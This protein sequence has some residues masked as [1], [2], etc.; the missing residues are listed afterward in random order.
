M[1]P[2]KVAAVLNNAATL[3][4]REGN[5]SSDE[6]SPSPGRL[7]ES[8]PEIVEV[9]EEEYDAGVP[10]LCIA[11]PGVHGSALQLQC[12][13]EVLKTE[14]DIQAFRSSHPLLAGSLRFHFPIKMP[15]H[16]LQERVYD[17][18]S[19]VTDTVAQD[20]KSRY[21]RGPAGIIP[22]ENGDNDISE[23]HRDTLQAVTY[24][25]TF[26]RP[27]NAAFEAERQRVGPDIYRCGTAIS[28]ADVDA[29]SGIL[30]RELGLQPAG[31]CVLD[32]PLPLYPGVPVV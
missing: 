7:T 11:A 32:F 29:D 9:R 27:R 17:Q 20:G 1:D 24:T 4:G 10:P 28:Q 8:D 6:V 3:Q 23:S 25:S 14:V 5:A 18:V 30:F 16:S 13:A 26:Q 22:T 15:R 19:K 21:S 12:A 2:R 31:F